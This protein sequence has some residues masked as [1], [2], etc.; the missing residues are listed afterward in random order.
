MKDSIFKTKD[1]A[2]AN[3]LL[4]L[5]YKLVQLERGD[6]KFVLFVFEIDPDE[7]KSVWDRYWR[8]EILIDAKTLI[9]NI[10]ELKSRLYSDEGKV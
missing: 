3:V 4:S 7:A 8:R 9:D 1:F 5:G 6:A 10:H 2:Q